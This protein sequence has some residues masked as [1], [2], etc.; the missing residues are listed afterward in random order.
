MLEESGVS[1]APP[2]RPR[3]QPATLPPPPPHPVTAC[4]RCSDESDVG[5][6]GEVGMGE[7]GGN[8]GGGSL[9]EKM[10]GGLDDDDQDDGDQVGSEEDRNKD[11][12]SDRDK[13][14]VEEDDDEMSEVDLQ[15]ASRTRGGIFR[16]K[17]IGNTYNMADHSKSNF[18]VAV[19]F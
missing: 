9:T 12:D 10:G 7:H 14:G 1:V 3:H 16:G 17:A 6:G 18:K 8:V 2:E 15:G 11:K 5:R 4:I 13:I 19:K